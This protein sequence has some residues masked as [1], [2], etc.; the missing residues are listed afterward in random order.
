MIPNFPLGIKPM[1]TKILYFAAGKEK[2]RA[3]GAGLLSALVLVVP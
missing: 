1:Q 2:P 3:D